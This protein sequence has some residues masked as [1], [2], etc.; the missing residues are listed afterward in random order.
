MVK[1]ISSIDRILKSTSN[2]NKIL[3]KAFNELPPKILKTFSKIMYSKYPFN[4][5][6]SISKAPENRKLSDVSFFMPKYLKSTNN[7]SIFYYCMGV[8]SRNRRKI[9]EFNKLEKEYIDYVFQ[10]DFGGAI[11]IL[12]KIESRFGKSFWSISQLINIGKLDNNNDT[13]LTDESYNTIDDILIKFHRNN[14]DDINSGLIIGPDNVDTES[15]KNE[16]HSLLNYRIY[17]LNSTESTFDI[18]HVICLELSSTLIDF[19]KSVETLFY[20]VLTDFDDRYRLYKDEVKEFVVSI[21][22]YFLT[23]V[24]YTNEMSMD[25]KELYDRYTL[26]DYDFII[27]DFSTNTEYDPSRF[28]LLSKSLYFKK[29]RLIHKGI[30]S[31]QANLMADVYSK[32][33]NFHKSVTYLS[34]FNL[35]FRGVLLFNLIK[36]RINIETKGYYNE[37][38]AYV[39][40]AELILSK[41]NTPLKFSKNLGWS[42][43]YDQFSNTGAT[44]D[45]FKCH[46][47]SNTEIKDERH[48]KYH[49]LNLIKENKINEASSL[50]EDNRYYQDNELSQIF[51]RVKSKNDEIMSA[52]KYFL[53]IYNN[54]PSAIN[55]FITPD[56]Y[57]AI[58]ANSKNSKNIEMAICLYICRDSHI[59]K[60]M[61][62]NAT[63]I[64]IGRAIKNLGYSNPSDLDI[65]SD[66][67]KAI[68]FLSDVCNKEL[69]TKSLL[70][71]TQS[72]AYDERIKICNI[73]V[74]N[75]LG[76]HEKLVNES[77]ALSKRKVLEVAE[78]QVNSTKIYADKD[79]IINN[80]WDQLNL[81]YKDFT[82]KHSDYNTLLEIEIEKTLSKLELDRVDVSSA[83]SLGLSVLPAQLI[84]Y[85][86]L[87]QNYKS[88]T[89]FQILKLYI[90]EYCFGLKGLNTY[91]S[92]R[93]RHGT[94][95]STI[96]SNL[97]TN[98]F[99]PADDNDEDKH[100]NTS[101]KGLNSNLL[102]KIKSK[103][104]EFKLHLNKIIN[105]IVND[106]VQICTDK[107]VPTIQK[108]NFYFDEYD[109]Y[110]IMKKFEVSQSFIESFTY[111]DEFIE[112]KLTDSCSNVSNALDIES[113]KKIQNLFEDFESFIIKLETEHEISV[114][115][116]F[117]RLV[118]NSKQHVLNQLDVII[119]WF[120]LKQDFHEETYDMDII[121]GIIKN[122]V[123]VENIKLI[124]SDRIKVNY[125]I[126]SA[127]VDIIYN[128][129]NNAIKYSYLHPSEINIEIHCSASSSSKT[130]TFEIRNDCAEERDFQSKNK[131]LEK[132][133]QHIS[134]EDLKK[135]MQREGGNTGIAKVKSAIRYELNAR[136]DVSLKYL[137]AKTFSA[138][139]VFTNAKG[140]GY[141]ENTNR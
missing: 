63:G 79:Y 66:D 137:T 130:V 9:I 127:I 90:E 70:Y 91:L 140:I 49:I 80:I 73:L 19:F 17:G 133:S 115:Y 50:L 112:E 12:R 129:V 136:E 54:F 120:K 1:K 53:I 84:Q 23:N 85:A 67:W 41:D 48:L 128:L 14:F 61:N 117:T 5:K 2:K 64:S 33:T 109:L 58:E 39:I 108:F 16:F 124:E 78:K 89:L 118:T 141:D 24:Y 107:P 45:L 103:R 37:R 87:G 65:K 62:Q 26:G 21:E 94:L 43:H 72:D 76:N 77:K 122:M 74:S 36:H 114:P 8:L 30:L 119:G 38:E 13:E 81:L 113:R 42:I 105:E 51:I 22:H 25:T 29:T 46:H 31:Q 3:E 126:L 83:T 27:N 132:Y 131:D 92:T 4:D 106:W 123:Q 34:N 44:A 6:E 104:L 11:Q 59:D 111:L 82:A 97:V 20:M 18:F 88:K 55:Y 98:G 116:E 95:E 71:R 10:G 35:A 69:L 102:D 99:F 138:T 56:F 68:F 75:K 57:M 100:F 15:M 125:H 135:L 52:C 121:I 139:V 93:I 7:D 86:A 60:K 110:N 134:T 40:K 28:N 101:L 47:H 32:N 96:T